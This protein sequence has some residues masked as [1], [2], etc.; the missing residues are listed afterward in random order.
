[1]NSKPRCFSPIQP[2]VF[3]FTLFALTI[4]SRAIAA[5]STVTDLPQWH[6]QY[7]GD[8][9][10]CVQ[11]IKSQWSWDRFWSRLSRPVPQAFDEA[12]EMAVFIAVG[13]RP[14]GGFR[15]RVVSATV[16]G[17]KLLIVYTDGKPSPETFVTQALTQPWVVA[18]IPKSSLPVVTQEV[19]T[20]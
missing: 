9:E 5:V 13:E 12:K 16:L 17:E 11:I 15:P 19:V 3:L 18:I 2:A 4:A 8:T 1:M 7:E 14:T 6:G 20:N 10:F